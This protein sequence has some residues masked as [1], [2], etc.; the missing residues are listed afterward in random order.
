M[1][2]KLG[3]LHSGPALLP[4]P[5]SASVN[6]LHVIT[7]YRQQVECD[8]TKFWQIEDTAIAP[9]ESDKPGHQFLVSYTNCHI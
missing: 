6:S 8:L 4:Q 1:S 7:G 3:Y 9:N 2:S 5:V